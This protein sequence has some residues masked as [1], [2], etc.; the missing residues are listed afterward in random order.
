MPAV[1]GDNG[2]V[3]IK[4]QS[5][6]G[7]GAVSNGSI[8]GLNR[9]VSEFSCSSYAAF[10]VE[11]GAFGSYTH[12]VPIAAKNFH[13]VFKEV[14]VDGV[15]CVFGVANGVVFEDAAYQVL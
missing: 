8:D 14:N 9:P 5:G 2:G 10:A 12:H 15:G 6:D 3:L 4:G 11:F 13:G 1:I 7:I